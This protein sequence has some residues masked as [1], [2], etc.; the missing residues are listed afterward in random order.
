MSRNESGDSPEYNAS[1]PADWVD[2]HGD[3]L[4]W[5]AMLRVRESELAEEVVQE[6]FLAALSAQKSFRTDSSERTWLIGILKHK[7]VDHFRR[8]SRRSGREEAASSLDILGEEFDDSGLWRSRPGPW[9]HGGQEEIEQ[10]E[11]REA[12]WHCLGELP[13]RM[14]HCFVLR[15]L[16]AMETK[17]ICKV[18]DTSATNVWVTLH[19]AR[20]G[21]RRCLEERWFERSEG[22]G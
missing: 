18:L 7:I 20:M 17:E 10:G 11:F 15:E 13:R 5:Y 12:L 3:A 14:A 22:K 19:R 21:L 6:T 1:A 8:D 2:R 9:P 16:E 4:F